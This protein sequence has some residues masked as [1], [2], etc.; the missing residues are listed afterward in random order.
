MKPSGELAESSAASPAGDATERRSALLVSTLASFLTPLQASS[1]VVALPRIGQDFAMDPVW[2][3]W[4]I[5]AFVLSAAIFLVP[6]GRLADIHGRKRVFARGVE[7]FTVASLLCALAPTA[8]FLIAARAIQ[9][10]G[11]TMIFGTGVAILT[12][13]YPASERGRVL[14]INVAAVYVGLSVGPPVGGLLTQHFGWRSI[15]VVAA[16]LG[17]AI[18]F[19][20][21]TR[22]RGE[23]AEARGEAFDGVGAVLYGVALVLLMLGL[24]R[25]PAAS[26]TA[27]LLAGTAAFAGFIGWE[28]R[29]P[30]PM[31]ALDLFRGNPVFTFSNLAALIHYS[32]TF[33]STFLLS[34]YLQYVRGL[35]PQAAGLVLLAQPV[36]MALGSPFAGRLSDR[37]EPR[38]VASVGMGLTAA[39]LGFFSLL[40][41]DTPLQLICA[42]LGLS[43][44]GFA[45]FSSPNTNA[46]MGAVE[47]RSYG[48]ASAIIGTMRLVGHMLS[49]GIAALLLA[50]YVGRQPVTA[51]LHPA[52]MDAAG[53]AFAIFAGLC[54]AGIFASL[55]RGKVR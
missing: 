5:T 15:F 21:W 1:V 41:T 12:S 29:T 52:F 43:G 37:V 17:L 19:A 18:V 24:S 47:K 11:S 51:A 39:A 44:L 54:V 2:V 22:L 42:N 26:G 9:G 45:L 38:T 40:G 20:T 25:V 7:I 8:G 10:F 3:S 6:F 23:W 36:V 50:M 4:V 33:G 46:V 32:A 35:G 31:M 34:L 30:S 27:L 55:A 53:R 49:V 28:R 14:G 48:L 16:V 13:V